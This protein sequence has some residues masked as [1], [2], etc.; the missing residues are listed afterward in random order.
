M[1]ELPGDSSALLL[2]EFIESNCRDS[3]VCENKSSSSPPVG[4]LQ[5]SV[6]VKV[7]SIEL[8]RIKMKCLLTLDRLFSKLISTSLQNMYTVER[9][10][11]LKLTLNYFTVTI[12]TY[13]NVTINIL[14]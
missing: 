11:K 8:T 14:T 6:I 2:F 4:R 9:L 1:F 13:K 3:M 12:K 5:N 10:L 7:R